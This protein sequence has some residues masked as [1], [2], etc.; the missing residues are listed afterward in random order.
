M[1]IRP[2]VK[3]HGGKYRIKNYIVS[4]L[5][6]NYEQ[7]T[8]CENFC[9]MASTLLNKKRSKREI[10][11][12]A[13]IV[14]IGLLDACKDRPKWLYEGFSF[15]TYEERT[16]EYVRD[17]HPGHFDGMIWREYVIRRMSRGGLGKDFA[18][19][20][21]LRGGIPGDV[22]SWVTSLNNIYKVSQRLQGV[23]T[24]CLDYKQSFLLWDSPDTIFYVDPPYLPSTRVTKNAYTCDFSEQ[25]HS[26]L[27]DI[28]SSVKGKVLL[29]G[30]PSR[31]YDSKLISWNRVQKEVA[32]NSGQN[33]KKQK[34]IEVLWKNY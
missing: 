7:M 17:S 11:S 13:N 9:G 20:N 25:D 15:L 8:Y 23:E 27:L 30:Y 18:W 32:N 14:T 31:L 33:K 6:Q 34:R 4:N 2:L 26:A 5:P 3:I 28:L 10:L 21:R 1:S 19:S 22:N 16:F 12:D 29:S 24:Y